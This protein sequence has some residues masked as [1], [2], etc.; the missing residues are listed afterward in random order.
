MKRPR[1]AFWIK[2]SAKGWVAVRHESPIWWC[3]TWLWRWAVRRTSAYR[4]EQN[5][6][7]IAFIRAEAPKIREGFAK[8]AKLRKELGG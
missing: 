5:M 1:I 4:K 3:P 6:I 8:L 7:A 2:R